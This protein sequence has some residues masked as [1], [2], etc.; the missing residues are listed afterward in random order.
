GELVGDRADIASSEQGRSFQAFYDFLLS[1]QRQDEL[2]T[3][4]AAVSEMTAVEADRRMRLLHHD[5]AG[6][7]ERTQAT[8]RMLSEQLRRFLDDR[9]W[10]ENRRVLDLAR[11]IEAAA[12]AVRNDP[13]DQGLELDEPGIPIAMPFERPLHQVRADT[14][15]SSLLGPADDG[16]LDLEALLRQRHVDVE[17]LAENIRA[18]VPPR[19]AAELS[20]ILSLYPVA[21]GAAEVI[22]YLGLDSHDDLELE[23]D[24]ERSMSVVYEG[25][26][27]VDRRMTIPHVTIKRS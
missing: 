23:I 20:E 8:V 19:S 2:S 6:A 7:A 1:E 21:D 17:R 4:L 5:W 13:P 22:A 25:L 10:F 27:G 3:L 18:V 9:V 24:A 14:A 26:D 12:I 16:P 11:A 15:V